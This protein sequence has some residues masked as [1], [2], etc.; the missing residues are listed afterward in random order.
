MSTPKIDAFTRAYLECALWTSDPDPQSGEWCESEWW[1]ISAIHPPDLERAI[2]DCKRFQEE[3]AGTLAEVSDT[4]HVDDTQHGHDFWLTRNG[5]GAGFWDRG[6]GDAGD[7]LTEAAHTFGEV[8]VDG[9]QT[10]DQGALDDGAL[11]AWD[12]VIYVS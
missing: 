11:D 9:P 6:Y 10:N 2:N 8:N 5:H 1:N 4:F 12:G 3:N 7:R